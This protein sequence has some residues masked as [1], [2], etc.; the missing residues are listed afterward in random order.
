MTDEKSVQQ[1]GSIPV[2]AIPISS[3][4]NILDQ[5]LGEILQNNPQA[6]QMITNSMGISQENFQKMVGSAKQNNL[7]QMKI[8][9]LFKNGI[10]QQAVQQYPVGQVTQQDTN[11][12]SMVVSGPM[13]FV[14]KQQVQLTPVQMNQL[15]NSSLNTQK[16]IQQAAPTTQKAS[17]IDKIRNWF[18]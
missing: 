5:T 9:D 14:G 4:G 1:P 7:M 3:K 15:Q 8:S 11:K 2:A 16:I 13:Q 6:Q 12:M 10:V 18:K 17:F